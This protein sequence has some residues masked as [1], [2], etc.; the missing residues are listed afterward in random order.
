M[1]EVSPDLRRLNEC[2]EAVGGVGFA[3]VENARVQFVTFRVDEEERRA[4]CVNERPRVR[5]RFS[6]E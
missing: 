1:S 2:V 3:H 6:C 4:V 5:L